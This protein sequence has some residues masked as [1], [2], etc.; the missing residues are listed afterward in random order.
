MT[1]D[2]KQNWSRQRIQDY[3]NHHRQTMKLKTL[4]FFKILKSHDEIDAT[5][6]WRYPLLHHHQHSLSIF[7]C[8]FFMHSHSIYTKP[9]VQSTFPSIDI[10]HTKQ[11]HPLISNHAMTSARYV[12][13]TPVH[14]RH[15]EYTSF[16][17]VDNVRKVMANDWWQ[18]TCSQQMTPETILSSVTFPI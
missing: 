5:S 10:L 14:Q 6:N 7:H 15:F 4:S 11:Q 12:V 16:C 3:S 2:T 8:L 13:Q 17:S 1:L 18:Q 9:R